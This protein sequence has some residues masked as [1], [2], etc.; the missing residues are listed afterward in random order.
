MDI[1]KSEQVNQE[2]ILNLLDEAQ[3]TISELTL[4][5]VRMK[6][7][8]VVMKSDFDFTISG[9]PYIAFMLLLDLKTGKYVSR[10]WNQTIAT[11]TALRKEE[12]LEACRSLFCQGRPCFGYPITATPFPRNVASTC[13]RVLGKDVAPDVTA[14]QECYRLK[15][16]C[17]ESDAQIKEESEVNAQENTAHFEVSASF[18]DYID[19]GD[20]LEEDNK[21]EHDSDDDQVYLKEDV[22][23]QNLEEYEQ[24]SQ[25]GSLIHTETKN[26]IH[27]KDEGLTSADTNV[28]QKNFTR[29]GRQ[30]KK[31]HVVRD[32]G[33]SLDN[34]SA[35]QNNFWGWTKGDGQRKICPV[36]SK[37]CSHTGYYDHMKM[38]HFYGRFACIQCGVKANSAADL[39]QHMNELLHTQDPFVD[40]PSCKTKVPL[41]EI[42]PHYKDCINK[43]D[44]ICPD[45]GKQF[46]LKQKLIEHM[47]VHMRQRGLT[48]E[49]ANTTLYYYCDQ[50]GGKY[51]SR[52]QLRKHQKNLH[53]G[54]EGHVPCPICGKEFGNDNLMRR[55]KQKEHLPPLQCKH[56]E[57]TT[58][59]H[60][61]LKMHT[62]KHFDPTFKCSY[63]E[64][65]LKS[66][67]SLEA[68]ERE[69]TGERP[70]K[71]SVCEKGFKSDTVLITHRKHVHKILTPRMKPIV[72]R[73]RKNDS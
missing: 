72:K 31:R 24:H 64:K 59:N 21:L 7:F 45:C 10:L 51:T 20:F 58:H 50:C 27:V 3:H 23:E 40:C 36:C 41:D 33:S 34:P 65:M 12:L 26:L 63:C 70:F 16:I 32:E 53:S 47:R 39:V 22:S 4:T 55:H 49:E 28:G 38:K 46:M 6:D 5:S 35:G 17:S 67:L 1:V 57:Y 71:C 68:H 30:R 62:R 11:G 43:K 56:C 73:V 44:Q 25:E 54:S 14:C 9:E 48:D 29:K 42:Q 61:H 66:K 13:S 2:F 15:T 69:H 19:S 8:L 37:S 52:Q 18:T 60:S